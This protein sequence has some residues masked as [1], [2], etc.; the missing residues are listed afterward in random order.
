MKNGPL[1]PGARSGG[2]LVAVALVALV[3][4]V[5]ALLLWRGWD[6]Y[7]LPLADRPDHPDFRV[8]RPTGTTGHTYGL[9]AALLIITNL[10]YLLRRRIPRLALGSMRV[11]LDV[12][13]ATGISAALLV[14]F[15]S[16]FQ[17]RSALATTTAVSLTIVVVTGIIGRFLRALLPGTRGEALLRGWRALHRLFAILMF[18]TVALHI[19]VAWHYGYRGWFS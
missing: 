6:F 4:A 18:A 13:A 5:T 16:A 11:W 7:R 10:S 12:H 9:V 14:A 17:L 2:G 15:H 8:L 19:A 3:A 1:P